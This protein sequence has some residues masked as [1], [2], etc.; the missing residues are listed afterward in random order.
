MF[1]FKAILIFNNLLGVGMLSFSERVGAVCGAS[2]ESRPRD[3]AAETHALLHSGCRITPLR[4]GW[5]KTTKILIKCQ[6]SVQNGPCSRERQRPGERWWCAGR[7]VADVAQL[8]CGG[9]RGAGGARRHH[10]QVGRIMLMIFP[11]RC[12]ILR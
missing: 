1:F 12:Y 5:T 9:H 8:V 4:L 7:H 10:P 11:I 6:W 3:V 2:T